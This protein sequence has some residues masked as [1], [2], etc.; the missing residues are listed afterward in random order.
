MEVES[1]A[2]TAKPK[3]LR[4]APGEVIKTLLTNLAEYREGNESV[5][6]LLIDT[7]ENDFSI[8]GSGY[9]ECL[10]LRFSDFRINRNILAIRY[11][12]I[13]SIY[14]F[15]RNSEDDIWMGNR[16]LNEEATYFIFSNALILDRDEDKVTISTMN[17]DFGIEITLKF[18][19]IIEI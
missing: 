1:I 16:V 15:E 2:E 13:P 10:V 14:V 7:D 12:N 17:G 8:M 9:G 11:L 18:K 4:F 5:Y 3:F 19:S 6:N